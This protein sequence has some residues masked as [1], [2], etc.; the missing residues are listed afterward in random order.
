M[1]VRCGTNVIAG[2]KFPQMS[3]FSRFSDDFRSPGNGGRD[4]EPM[5]G[6]EPLTIHLRNGRSAC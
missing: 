2:W 5:R 4:R 3:D 1:R 6:I